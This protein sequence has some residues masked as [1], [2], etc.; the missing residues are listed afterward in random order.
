MS[1]YSTQVRFICENAIGLQE[2][3]A[4][5][6][7]QEILEQAAPKVFNF[8]YPIFDENYRTP[9]EIKILRHFYLRE[10]GA[11]TVGVWKLFLQDKLN[12][13][14]PYYNQLYKSELLKFPVFED[15]HYVTLHEK[16]FQSDR[17]YGES[18]DNDGTSGYGKRTTQDTDSGYG[19]SGKS[20]T[21]SGYGVLRKQDENGGFGTDTK[22]DTTGAYDKK[23]DKDSRGSL[24]SDVTT[25]NNTTGKTVGESTSLTDKNGKQITDG[26]SHSDGSTDT[27]TAKTTETDHTDWKLSND[28]PQGRLQ[29]IESMAYLTN[30]TKDYGN[31]VVDENGKILEVRVEDVNTNQ[32]TKSE[33]T[34]EYEGHSTEDRTGQENGTR[35]QNDSTTGHENWTEDGSDEGH[36]TGTE[37]GSTENHSTGTENQSAESHT[38]NS[39]NQSAESHTIGTENQSAESHG[40][41]QKGGSE[42]IVTDEDFWQHVRG[43]MGSG[44]SY[45]QM[46][47][48]LRETFLNIDRMILQDL[49]ELF[50]LIY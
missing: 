29:D 19:L 43:K 25:S 9:L 26:T 18:G 17:G 38:T 45:S 15:T 33:E 31:S 49:E 10:I 4:F 21:D 20:D 46:L 39:E 42:N 41:Y 6:S 47:L 30:A 5:P 50:M 14:M 23:G 2:S 36:K 16:G 13:I 8:Q 32:T 11:E 1:K 34:D 27:T 37:T 22:E 7:I 35:N 44:K 3:L 28:T 40:E 24:D 12:E 48:E